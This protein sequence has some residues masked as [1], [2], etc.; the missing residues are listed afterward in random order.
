MKNIFLAVALLCGCCCFAPVLRAQN[1]NCL[2]GTL[3]GSDTYSGTVFF[4]YG[5]V[6]NAFNTKNQTTLSVGEPLIGPY[7]GQQFNGVAGFYSRFLLPPTPPTVTATEGDLKDR[8]QIEWVVDPLSP[9]PEL[10]FNI[11]RDGAFIGHVEKEIRLF[12]DFNVQAGQFYNYQIS[13]VNPFGEGTK[14]S[15]LGFL[16]P[17]GVVT[18]Q[19]RTFSGN[20]VIGAGVTLSPTLGTALQFTG[21]DVAFAPFDSALIAPKWTVSCWV[22]IGAGNNNGTI[23][24]FGSNVQKNWWLTT[25]GASKG[26][27]F[28]VGNGTSTQ[29]ASASFSSDPDGWHHVAATYSG[30]SLLLYLDG[31]LAGTLS[32]VPVLNDTLPLFFGRKSGA[33][34]NYFN[35]SLDDV[36]IFRRQLSQTEINQ[37]KNRTVNSDAEGLGAYWKFDEG[38]GSKGYDISEKRLKTYLCGP[39][40]SPNRPDVVNG[41]VTDASGFYKI[42]G[43]NYGGGTTFTATPSKTAYDNYALEFN[44]ANGNYVVLTD[45]VL[46]APQNAAVELRIQNFENTAAARTVLA[47]QSSN[48]SANFFQFNLSSGNIHVML[49]G[50]NKTF[51]ALGAGYQHIVV[52]LKK[53]GSTTDVS[54]YKNGALASTQNYA[55]SLP[56]FGP[57]TWQLGARKTAGGYDQFFSG[58]VDEVAFYDTLLTLPEIQ[59]NNVK[60]ADATHPR[61]RSWFPLNESQG[62]EV[63]DIGPARA[64]FG[65]IQGALWSTVTGIVSSIDHA[66][67]PDKRLVTLNA[68][69]TSTDQIDFIDLSTVSVSGYVRFDGTDCFAEGVEIFV[70]GVSANPKIMTDSTG[71]FV[72]DFEPGETVLLTP[73]FGEHTFS[74]ASWQ[75][76]NLN[77]PVAG[78]LF[79]DL[80]KRSLRGTVTGGL[81]KKGLLAPG[82]NIVVK[83]ATPGTNPCFERTFTLNG[84]ADG[85]DKTYVFAGLPPR[86]LNVSIVSSNPTSFYNYFQIQGG[87][88]V[89]LRDANDTIDFNYVAPPQMEVVEGLDTNSCGA[90]M[91]QQLVQYALKFKVFQSYAGGKCY[92]DEAYFTFNNGLA[93]SP[94]FDTTMT[95]GSLR[96]TFT[97]GEPNLAAP[98]LKTLTVTAMQSDSQVFVLPMTAVVLGDKST[99]TTFAATMPQFP[100]F[101]L[102]DPPGDASSAYLAKGKSTCTNLS[103]GSTD[104]Y[105]AS[106]SFSMLLGTETSV[107][108]GVPGL[109]TINTVSIEKTTTFTLSAGFS[110]TRENSMDVCLTADETISTN[111][112]DDLIGRDADIFV[113]GALNFLFGVTNTLN[114]DSATC[115]YSLGKGL[116]AAPTGLSSTYV[117][118]RY[119]I[120]NQVIPN[121]LLSGLP[122]AA[123]DIARWNQI[124][125]ADD[126]LQNA[127]IFQENISF[128]GGVTYEK[129]LT[130]ERSETNT[131]SAEIA[132]SAA[133]AQEAALTTN[134]TGGGSAFEVNVGWGGSLSGSDTESSATT[135]GYVLN[136]DDI[137]DLFSVTVKR[138]KYYGTPVFS[139]VAGETSCP[140]EAPTQ[141]R[142]YVSFTSNTTAIANVN[143]NAAAVFNLTLGNQ[144]ETDEERTYTLSIGSNP[145][146]AIVKAEGQQL[147]AQGLE[148]TIPAGQSVPVLLTVERGNL[149]YTYQDIEIIL[150]ASCEDGSVEGFSKS[151]LLDVEFVEPCSEVDIAFPMQNDVITAVTPNPYQVTL[152]D[153]DKND[154]DLELIRIQ[155]RPKFGDGSWINIQPQSDIL[156][157]NLAPVSTTVPWN[158]GTLNDGPYELRALTQCFGGNQAPGISKII[159][160]RVERNPPALLG[161]PQ[162]AD[163][164]LSP[165]DEISISFNEEINCDVLIQADI[166]QNNNIGLYDTETGNLIDATISCFENKIVVVP[167]IQNAFIEGKILRVEVD[168]IE[169][170]AGNKFL[171]AD[172]EFYVNR[173]P[174]DLEGGDLDVTMYEGE[175]KIVLRNLANVGGSITAFEIDN[176]P[177]WANIYPNIGS[178]LPGEEVLVT[179]KFDKTL[180]QGQYQDTI[181]FKNAQ[182]DERVIIKLRVLCPA[183]A[184]DFDA[185]S[186]PATMN[187]TAKLNI[188]GTLSIDEEDQVAAFI[189]GEL[190]GSAHIKYLAALDQYMAFLTV[191]GAAGDQGKAVNLQ[192]RDASACLLYG[193]VVEQFTF[194]QDNVHGTVGAPVILHTNSQVRR[195]IPLTTG[196]NWISFNLALPD[197]ALNAALSSLEHP[198]NDLF[199]SQSAF[200]EYFSGNWVGSLNAVNNS[201][202]F[203][204]RADVAD[205]IRMVGALIDPTTV[206][207][208][209]AA[210]WN[211][212]GYVPNYALPL[213]EALAGL[214]PLNG[215]LIKGQTAFAQYL[216]GFGWL[217]SLQFLEAPKGYQLK[218]GNPGTLTYPPQVNFR[219][220][221]LASRGDDL[222]QT[223]YWTVDPAAFEY[224]M[225]LVGMFSDTGANITQAGQELGVFAGNELRGAAQAIFIEPLQAHLFFLTVYANSSGEPLHFKL[226]DSATGQVTELAEQIYF[227]ANLHQGEIQAPVPFTAETS[228]VSDVPDSI[229]LDVQPNP[230]RDVAF[231]RFSSGQSREVMI[232]VTDVAGRIVLQQKMAPVSDSSLLRWDAGT[233][234][235]GVYF[236]RMETAEGALVRKVVKE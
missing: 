28:N 173:S 21:D 124:L 61:L 136:D 81:C 85:G 160:L 220:N 190:R 72:A 9:S 216:A 181:W 112:A 185:A 41:A 115:G 126:S 182:G 222:A 62:V 117:Y 55:V 175:E 89:D 3:T 90:P 68:S 230:F 236:V 218:I 148:F 100:L 212:I 225:T 80:T 22:K 8:I 176:A 96:Y 180:P 153:Y 23:L 97:G 137:G 25:N 120:V 74:P 52:N 95:G 111:G 91:I 15:G 134:G 106:K 1:A 155:Y 78:I 79:R 203:Q 228:G 44:G 58:L 94:P 77:A 177:D 192:I 42:E 211:W 227:A 165:G 178:L 31:S 233:V 129:S 141:K 193:E 64:G 201:G 125:A 131:Y 123:D 200:S 34:T 18:G 221:E 215:D 51:G 10:G 166:F 210:G 19:V 189:D 196:W 235:A 198:Q 26:I 209:I 118:Q 5:S 57:Q 4:N 195:D 20:P 217:G 33:T 60:G 164:V 38:I 53:N 83:V 47:N 145:L 171:H 184:W 128:T 161:Q 39:E 172:W 16:N 162:P 170:L 152:D 156:K 213:N 122:T 179:Y 50:V 63:E 214:A 154:P 150:A 224:S 12:V 116:M 133:V 194:E 93:D 163:G 37:Y 197:P 127:A 66:F 143:S 109:G 206:Q 142:N 29:T 49:G 187:F 121:L 27:R 191:Y 102:R 223:G 98:H 168:D 231:I 99:G 40:W 101:V 45:S 188:E 229:S 157:A 84:D 132:V 70:N 113:G 32:P 2:D 56:D 82:Q 73:Q 151:L 119:D 232:S 204:Y 35:G 110:E 199:K 202:M 87:E 105:D 24:D 65:N 69:N 76:K 234:Q 208:P 146:G 75:L 108:S 88:T 135:V 169:D 43:I 114:F 130:S 158:A 103:L 13:G 205:T 67:Q 167:N 54:L 71:K 17:N 46:P 147:T 7:F 174:L 138:D 14:G 140:W 149:S 104:A 48:G 107:V 159:N 36:R 92:L 139:L 219:E 226:F 11:Y 6:V 207:I 144:S 183:P 30:A 86:Q 59:L 186:Y